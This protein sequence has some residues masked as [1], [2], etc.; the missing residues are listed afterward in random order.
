MGVI[1]CVKLLI[2]DTDSSL[3]YDHLPIMFFTNAV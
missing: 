2:M 1:I 3:Q